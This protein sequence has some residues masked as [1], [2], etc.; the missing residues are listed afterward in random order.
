MHTLEQD[1]S[2][3]PSLKEVSDKFEQ[4]RLTRATKRDK[5][6]VE[7]WQQVLP[8]VNKYHI[9]EISKVLRLCGGQ[10]KALATKVK[11]QLQDSHTPVK[12]TLKPCDFVAINVPPAIEEIDTPFTGKVEIKRPDGVVILIEHLNQ[13]AL[14]Q[15]LTQFM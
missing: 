6:P 15:L 12:T 13:K 10:I 9:G 4:W 5:I 1:Q 8:L 2:S 14:T 11:K 7:L 3:V